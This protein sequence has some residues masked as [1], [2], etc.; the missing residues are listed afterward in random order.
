MNIMI[1]NNKTQ[2]PFSEL[3]FR[4]SRSGG[5]GGQNVNR[6]STRVE[7]IFDVQ[8]SPSLDAESKEVLKSALQ[9]KL[10]SSGCLRIVSQE[11]RSQWKNKQTAIERFGSVVRKALR[12]SKHRTPS[13]ATKSSKEE[14]LSKKKERGSMKKLRRLDLGKELD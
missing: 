9:S 12:P 7:L 6:V 11:S 14:R 4:F 2:I 10:D 1:I 5:P 8:H 13:T 3:R